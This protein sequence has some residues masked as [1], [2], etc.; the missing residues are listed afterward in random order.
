VPYRDEAYDL[1]ILFQARNYK[2]SEAEK[3]KMEE[4]TR[5][6]RRLVVSFPVADLHVEI[7]RHPRMKDFHVKTI[8]HLP[9]RALFTG[10][11]DIKVHPAYER[12]VRKLLNK[13]Q[14]YKERMGGK[15]EKEQ[16]AHGI[17]SSIWPSVEP[18]E[19]RI[20][21]AVT[22]GDFV[23]FRKAMAVYDEP[24][25]HRVG[26][27]LQRYPRAEAL[28]G[29]EILL[30]EVVEEVYL[31]AFERF[32]GRPKDRLGNWLR[33]LIAPSI[34]A[35]MGQGGKEIEELRLVEEVLPT[36]GSLTALN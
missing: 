33:R 20:R 2:L 29:R 36:G 30:S 18:D 22:E 19:P 17:E 6:L 15:R 11:R 28:L 23:A 4:D 24:L 16:L 13:V 7:F 5:T 1:R 27:L 3:R 34:R 26:R 21:R 14:A 10:D 35:L 32:E 12:C 31:N 9:G 8:L 25:E